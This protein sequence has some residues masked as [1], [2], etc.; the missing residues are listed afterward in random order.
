MKVDELHS[1]QDENEKMLDKLV[2]MNK[3][4]QEE[5]ESSSLNAILL[6]ISLL[7]VIPIVSEMVIKIYDKKF[8]SV[9]AISY[10]I[11]I[12]SCFFLWMLYKI[13]VQIRKRMRKNK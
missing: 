12:L 9:D 7:G 8:N 10:I 4:K 13:G 6:I 5:I 1:Y 2:Q 11:S 3:L